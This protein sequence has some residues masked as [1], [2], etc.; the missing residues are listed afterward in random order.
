MS[1]GDGMENYK[2]RPV[3]TTP[4]ILFAKASKMMLS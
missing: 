3:R 2:D 1:T 4:E